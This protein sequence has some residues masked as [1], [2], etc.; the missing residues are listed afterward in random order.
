MSTG[1]PRNFDPNTNQTGGTTTLQAI[2]AYLLPV[3]ALVG[4]FVCLI[5]GKVQADVAIP[6]ITAIV[7]VHI[8]AAITSS[9]NNP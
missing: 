4:V 8:G 7:G 2:L 1:Q 6:L 9:S 3:I 5:L